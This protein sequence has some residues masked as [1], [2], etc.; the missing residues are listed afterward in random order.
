MDLP[1]MKKIRIILTIILSVLFIGNS[2][3]NNKKEDSIRSFN[4]FKLLR[5]NND[6][7]NSGNL[8][9]IIF[10]P[11][12]K[13]GVVKGG[14]QLTDGDYHRIREA[15]RKNSYSLFSESYQVVN[16][17]YFYG[18]INY[19]NSDEKGNL[20]GAFMIHTGKSIHYWRFHIW[21]ELS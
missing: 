7:L 20:W 19:Y 5:L 2:W 21:S 1:D 11:N 13:I 10:N 14:Y 6:W 3:S 8:A 16:D 12:E 15:T 17:I 4:S 9:G 18:K